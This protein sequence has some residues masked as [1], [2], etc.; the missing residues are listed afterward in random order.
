MASR[1]GDV[2]ELKSVSIGFR[3][4]AS[5][6]EAIGMVRL[7]I[8]STRTAGTPTLADVL[9]DATIPQAMISRYTLEPQPHRVLFDRLV[10]LTTPVNEEA[11]NVM[12]NVFL[13]KELGRIRFDP[14]ATSADRNKIWVMALGLDNTNVASMA[15][16]SKLMFKDV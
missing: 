8:V 9:E 2:I 5:E 4:I 3:F 11:K 16:E 7:I 6:A 14:T 13:R 15:F 12:F 1:D 10:N